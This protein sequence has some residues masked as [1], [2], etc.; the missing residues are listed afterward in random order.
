MKAAHRIVGVGTSAGG[1]DA[2]TRF[3][4]NIALNSNMSFVVVPHLPNDSRTYLDFLLSRNTPLSVRLLSDNIIPQPDHI[5]VLPGNKRVTI[6]DGVLQIRA[7]KSQEIINKAVDEFLISLAKDQKQNAVAVI[8][9]GMGSDGSEGVKAIHHH[10][11]VVLVQSPRST[12]F[13][14][15]PRAAINANDPI[16]ITSPEELG[17][18]LQNMLII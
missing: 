1:L 18:A 12:Q 6:K 5:Y 17:T 3:F 15:M 11:G 4:Q 7:R 14:S 2:L 8:L 16:E 10:G 13:D 9:S